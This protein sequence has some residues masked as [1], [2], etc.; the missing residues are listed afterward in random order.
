MASVTCATLNNV[1]IEGP[2]SQRR[3]ANT[4][5]V[6]AAAPTH[7][8]ANT[9]AVRKGSS[10]L[11]PLI[12]FPTRYAKICAIKPRTAKQSA[13]FARPG[14]YVGDTATSASTAMTAML[15]T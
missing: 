14:S 4:A 13:A 9:A 5:P 1:L 10:A 15:V 12:P 3:D 6:T 2:L 7:V 8:G 11:E